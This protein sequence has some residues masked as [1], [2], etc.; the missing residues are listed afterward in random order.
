[1]AGLSYNVSP[2][3]EVV[4][5]EISGSENYGT[6]GIIASLTKTVALNV[7][8]A[9]PNRA[10]DNPRGYVFNSAYTF[11]LKGGARAANDTGPAS[12][13]PSGGGATQTK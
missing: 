11:H 9:Q 13:H 5:D 2:T 3:I 8:Y 10:D 6:L 1:M 12:H 7:A 4:G